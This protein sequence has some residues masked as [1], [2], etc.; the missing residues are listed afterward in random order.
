MNLETKLERLER[1]NPAMSNLFTSIMM[2]GEFNEFKNELEQ[3]DD[4]EWMLT[5]LTSLSIG[6]ICQEQQI[7]SCAFV[8]GFAVYGELFK[9][10]KT[11]P[12]KW[13]GSYDIDM[14]A[15]TDI[16]PILHKNF[17]EVLKA[18]EF[19]EGII[20]WN[21]KL[22]KITI[23]DDVSYE[24][25]TAKI[26][27]DLWL[28]GKTAQYFTEHIDEQFWS[29]TQKMEMNHVNI[30]IA[31]VPQLVRLKEG[32]E[33]C[34]EK[35]ILDLYTLLYLAESQNIPIQ[36]SKEKAAI[37]IEKYDAHLMKKV[38]QPTKDYLSGFLG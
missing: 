34:R 14:V 20:R 30:I 25:I 23:Y 8:G 18:K 2:N 38:I 29:N 24:P 22:D 6:K 9:H 35:D 33:I 16:V 7:P 36:I 1:M 37:L 11:P 32:I 5:Y 19:S 13:R 3:F 10:F 28:P 31:A 21:I 27:L 4:E 26:P 17:V 12:F 15:E